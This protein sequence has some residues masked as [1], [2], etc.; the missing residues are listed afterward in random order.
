MTKRAIIYT[1]VICLNVLIFPLN[2]VLEASTVSNDV[3]ENV[4][5]DLWNSGI[6]SDQRESQKPQSIIKSKK[7][8]NS[9][10]ESNLP[11]EILLILD[12]WNFS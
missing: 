5:L 6:E 7:G 11:E 8:V 3:F 4:K 1:V 12:R 9:L 2:T 10:P